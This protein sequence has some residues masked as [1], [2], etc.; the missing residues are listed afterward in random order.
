MFHSTER[1]IHE[2]ISTTVTGGLQPGGRLPQA[3]LEAKV[4]TSVGEKTQKIAQAASAAK[5]GGAA[6]SPGFKIEL[7]VKG[8]NPEAKPEDPAASAITATVNLTVPF[9]L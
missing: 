8:P 6:K 4:K 5:E 9:S 3:E 2:A 1:A 7:T